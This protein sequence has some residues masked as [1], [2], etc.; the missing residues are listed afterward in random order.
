[1]KNIFLFGFYGYGNLGDEILLENS[2][3]LLS[4]YDEIA[5]LV[6]LSPKIPRFSGDGFINFELDNVSKYNFPKLLKAINSCD[7]MIG[8][9][10]GIFQDETSLRSFLY[11]SSLVKYALMAKK[12]VLL[13]GQSLGPLRSPISR[14]VM[15]KILVSN[16]VYPLMRDPVSYRYA[17]L[18][19]KHAVLSTDLAFTYIPQIPNIEKNPK[20]F[21]LAIKEPLIVNSDFFHILKSLGFKK[22]DLLIFFPKEEEKTALKNM[23]TLKKHFE[24]SIS[25]GYKRIVESIASSSLTFTQRLH[26]AILSLIFSTKFIASKTPKI[27]RTFHEFT[28][29]GFAN[30]SSSFELVDSI[31]KILEFDFESY[32][33]KTLK[34]FLK[35]SENVRKMLNFFLEAKYTP[36]NLIFESK[37]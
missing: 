4:N 36:K 19:S 34:I 14:R 23:E 8:G 3:R 29:P 33:R 7:L 28:Y 10:G 1:V 26:G 31:E 11:Y 20:K 5:K 16:L 22:V 27:V 30:F 15:K 13:L 21:S 18:F 17:K 37:T 12:P 2:L 24:V 9:G 6:I 35:R 25:I 32:R